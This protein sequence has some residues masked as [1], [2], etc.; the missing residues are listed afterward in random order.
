MR[1]ADLWGEALSGGG[2]RD[3]INGND[4]TLN[5]S[6]EHDRQSARKK[7]SSENP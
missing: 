4:C 6:Y 1:I 7:P 5:W 3:A 2:K